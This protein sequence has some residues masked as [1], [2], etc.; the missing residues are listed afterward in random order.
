MYAV[1][2]WIG[3]FLVKWRNFIESSAVT[4]KPSLSNQTA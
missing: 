4:K 2:Q 3:Q 1:D